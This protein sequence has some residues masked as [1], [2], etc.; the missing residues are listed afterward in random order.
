MSYTMGKG[1]MALKLKEN[2]VVP[3]LVALGCKTKGVSLG[4]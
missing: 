3:I 1:S 4:F 2:Y